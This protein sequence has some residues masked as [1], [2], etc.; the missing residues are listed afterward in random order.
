MLRRDEVGDGA[1]GVGARQREHL[2]IQG[3]KH[4]RRF[5]TRLAR[6]VGGGL[7]LREVVTHVGHG[8]AVFESA[9]RH[10]DGIV[11]AEAEDEAPLRK[12]RGSLCSRGHC[13]RGARPDARDAG[14]DNQRIG[15]RQ[16]P[17]RIG[18]RVSAEAFDDPESAI[19]EALNRAREVNALRAVH[20]IEERKDAEPADIH[21]GDPW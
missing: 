9:I 3:G 2:R 15:L 8:L 6:L 19:A 13:A 17:W 12:L 18:E 10:R 7:H 5:V 20:R 1:V 4:D 16:Q 14:A 21:G 11:R